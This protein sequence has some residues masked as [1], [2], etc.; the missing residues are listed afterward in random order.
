MSKRAFQIALIVNYT[1]DPESSELEKAWESID[2][3]PF[4]LFIESVLHFSSMADCGR[5]KIRRP[6][7]TEIACEF[8]CVINFQKLCFFR[9]V[10]KR[11]QNHFKISAQNV[12]FRMPNWSPYWK[13]IRRCSSGTENVRTWCFRERTKTRRMCSEEMVFLFDL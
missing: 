12:L 4:G 5:Q 2:T 11:I 1:L 9:E 7:R 6:W 13:W 10:E 3:M 8:K